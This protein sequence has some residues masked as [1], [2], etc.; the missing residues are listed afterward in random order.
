[1]LIDSCK[2]YSLNL[3]LYGQGEPWPG[4][5][6]GKII[7][8]RREIER[9]PTDYVLVCDASDAFF[10]GGEDSIL[11]RFIEMQAPVV[12]SAEKRCWPQSSLASYFPQVDTPWKYLNSGGYIGRKWDV[13]NLLRYLEA[14]TVDESMFRS[15]DWDVDQFRLSL[16]YIDSI[17]S[18]K[19]DTRCEIFQTMGDLAKDEISWKG[20]FCRNLVTNTFPLVV[21]YNGHAPGSKHTF[22]WLKKTTYPHV[23]RL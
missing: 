5:L 17:S 12:I 3:H 14:M 21:H 22:T 4:L 13:V 23:E 18:I 1:M 19:L 15:R 6:N 16:V 8:L 11:S 9:L 2:N 20:G 10:V 7:N